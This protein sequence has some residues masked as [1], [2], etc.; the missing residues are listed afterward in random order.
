VAADDDPVLGTRQYRLHEAELTDG[1]F[2]GVELLVADLA[3]VGGI[4]TQVVDG[5]LGDLEVSGVRRLGHACL[6]SNVGG[7][8]KGRSPSSGQRPHSDGC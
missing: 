7:Q 1:A 8:E 6:S 5:D 3:R 4:G 2:E